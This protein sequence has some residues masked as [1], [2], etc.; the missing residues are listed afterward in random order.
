[1]HLDSPLSISKQ[2]LSESQFIFHLPS[3]P[4]L[5]PPKKSKLTLFLV[6]ILGVNGIIKQCAH[7]RNLQV[8]ITS[9]P[10]PPPP[11]DY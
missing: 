4:P 5:P 1:M 6:F 3:F 8:I 11:L 10:S 9:S 7:D 2:A